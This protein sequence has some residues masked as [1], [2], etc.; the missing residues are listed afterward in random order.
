MEIPDPQN[1]IPS[2]SEATSRLGALEQPAMAKDK[3]LL[4]SLQAILRKGWMLMSFPSSEEL[5]HMS[6]LP[7]F[8]SQEHQCLSGHH[9]AP[10]AAKH[11]RTQG[12]TGDKDST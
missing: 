8:P 2:S 10:V 3:Q 7:L 9:L 11:Q 12:P 4:L 5:M 1:H 6:L